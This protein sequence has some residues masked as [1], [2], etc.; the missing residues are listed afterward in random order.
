MVHEGK[1]L[2]NNVFWFINLNEIIF[3]PPINPFFISGLI[4]L[5][6]MDNERYLGR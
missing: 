2:K 5:C 3:S 1:I 6:C 4:L